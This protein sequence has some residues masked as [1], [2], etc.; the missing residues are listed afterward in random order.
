MLKFVL[1][2]NVKGTQRPTQLGAL[3]YEVDTMKYWTFDTLIPHDI[4]NVW[5]STDTRLKSHQSKKIQPIELQRR[6]QN[7]NTAVTKANI[8]VAQ[9]VPT[10][11]QIIIA[12]PEISNILNKPWID[13]MR[14]FKWPG[15]DGLMNFDKLARIAKA[16]PLDRYHALGAATILCQAIIRVTDWKSQLSTA[17][18]TNTTPKPKVTVEK[19]EKGQIKS[20]QL[21]T[22][23]PL[24]IVDHFGKSIRGTLSDEQWDHLHRLHG[25]RPKRKSAPRW[26]FA[27]R[28]RT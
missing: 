25:W 4:S 2:V 21:T 11:K 5:N 13:T 23:Q 3:L 20:V 16:N 6:Y 18:N 19:D 17:I 27:K 7:F 8:V 9:N 28:R 26:V 1:F 12:I 22:Q 10:V 24:Q 14:E 15:F